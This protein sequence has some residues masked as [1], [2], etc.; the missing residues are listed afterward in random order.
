[1]ADEETKDP[2]PYDWFFEDEVRE[3]TPDES[4]IAQIMSMGFSRDQ[5]TSALAEKSNDEA[6]ALHMLLN[7]GLLWKT[8]AVV[9]QEKRM[10]ELRALGVVADPREAMKKQE[11]DEKHRA[12]LSDLAYNESLRSRKEDAEAARAQ[13]AA[14]KAEAAEK[15]LADKARAV[16]EAAHRRQLHAEHKAEIQAVR[17]A[18]KLAKQ[19]KTLP[20]N[21]SQLRCQLYREVMR[22]IRGDD[23]L[24]PDLQQLLVAEG[25]DLVALRARSGAPFRTD[26]LKQLVREDNDRGQFLDARNRPE[27]PRVCGGKKSRKRRTKRR[28]KTGGKKSRKQRKRTTIKG[29]KRKR[30]RTR[31]RR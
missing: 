8:E 31:R 26:E 16:E 14:A 9:A 4:A 13:E 21:Q 30:R 18:D 11:A 25:V 19:L 24:M 22:A 2:E 17:A 10:A 29:G 27:W 12:E 20:M 15:L 1:M 6:A 5:A 7:E 23:S 3:F 28:H